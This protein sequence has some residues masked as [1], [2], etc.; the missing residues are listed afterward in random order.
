MGKMLFS[1][2]HV[3]AVCAAAGYA[4]EV[5]RIDLHSVDGTI[6]GR[7]GLARLDAQI[8]CTSSL[9]PA[10]S[11]IAYP[12]DVNNYNDLADPVSTRPIILILVLAPRLISD[13]INQSEEEML[14]RKCAYWAWL[15]G[16]PSSNNRSSRTIHIQRTQVFTVERVAQFMNNLVAQNELTE[17]LA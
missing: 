1:E 4:F 15:Q 5:D 17:G 6:K 13:W 2:A 14:M 9:A 16:E 10:A 7:H 3:Q 11:Y 8:K 12:L